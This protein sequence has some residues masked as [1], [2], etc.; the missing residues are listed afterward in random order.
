MISIIVPVYNVEKYIRRCVDSIIVQTYKDWELLL[1]DDGSPDNSGKICDEYASKDSRIKV[2]HKEN[3]GV[4]SARNLGLEKAN[5][6]WIVFVDSDDILREDALDIMKNRANGTDMSFFNYNIKFESGKENHQDKL[7]R[8]ISSTQLI[9]ELLCYKISGAP[10]SKIYRTCIAKSI[11][12]KEDVAI[13]EDLFYNIE[14][15]L[16]SRKDVNVYND[17]VYDYCINTE[18]VMQKKDNR[19]KYYKMNQIVDSIFESKEAFAQ[20]INYFKIVN[21]LQPNFAAGLLPSQKE[22][23]EILS[24]YK[25]GIPDDGCVRYYKYIHNLEKYSGAFANM[26][27]QLDY[28]KY[29]LKKFIKSLFYCK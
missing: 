4:S 12:F 3:G 25:Q 18:S 16:K 8:K 29:C 9:N 26:V 28:T 21:I 14:F 1:I 11:K 15:L 27:L 24:L 20:N 22:R 6:E 17:I 23:E 10:F 19:A 7:E 13:G 2:F 5:G